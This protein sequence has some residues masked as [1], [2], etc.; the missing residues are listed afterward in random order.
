MKL[1]KSLSYIFLVLALVMVSSCDD[2]LTELNVNPKG[3]DPATVNPNLMVATVISHT[4]RPHFDCD[5]AGGI[6]V[7]HFNCGIGIR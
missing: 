2:R 7:V 5:H 1:I 3:V 6:D 4:A